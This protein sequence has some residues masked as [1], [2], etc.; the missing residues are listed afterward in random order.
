MTSAWGSVIAHSLWRIG[1]GLE[2]QAVAEAFPLLF[3][4][5]RTALFWFNGSRI[6]SDPLI[7]EP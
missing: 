2:K 7:L 5:L 4:I 1:Y 3:N 6:L